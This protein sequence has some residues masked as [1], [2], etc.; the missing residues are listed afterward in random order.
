VDNYN[1]LADITLFVQGNPTPH[2]K[3]RKI[4]DFFDIPDPSLACSRM[5]LASNGASRSLTGWHRNK[6]MPDHINRVV[7]DSGRWTSNPAVIPFPLW[8]TKYVKLPIPRADNVR[9]SWNAIFSVTKPYVWTNSRRY[10]KKLLQTVT[11]GSDP[12]EGHF[13]E[14]AWSY[15]FK[16]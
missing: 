16:P 10:Y 13:L 15:I 8:W 3:G 12:E 7:A 14:R 4:A 9:F 11:R 5:R 1:N 6:P 2:L